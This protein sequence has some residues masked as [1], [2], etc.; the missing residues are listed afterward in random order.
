M[1]GDYPL[2]DEI[3]A[4]QTMSEKADSRLVKTTVSGANQSVLYTYFA[5]DRSTMDLILSLDN[6]LC[7][8]FM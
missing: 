2:W 5:G 6:S 4:K 3:W 8:G 1:F 7:R